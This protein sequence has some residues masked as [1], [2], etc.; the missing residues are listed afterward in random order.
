MANFEVS[1]PIYKYFEA[2]EKN[3]ERQSLKHF[4][5]QEMEMFYMSKQLK[6]EVEEEIK[7]GFFEIRKKHE[8]GDEATDKQV[9]VSHM[10]LHNF[11]PIFCKFEL[12]T[13]KII[14][15]YSS[16][17]YLSQTQ[18]LYSPTVNPNFI[19]IILFGKLRLFDSNT[20]QRIGKVINIGWTVGEDIL[21]ND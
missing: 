6:P 13:V 20:N 4:K 14:L 9:Y 8:E 16:I 2:A 7:E 17:V 18:T 3:A 19:Y 1:K 15:H 12:S 11:H 10:C 21:F 5:N